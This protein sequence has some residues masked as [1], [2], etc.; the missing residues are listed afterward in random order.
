MRSLSFILGFCAL[1]PSGGAQTATA[2][3]EFAAGM[4][5]EAKGDAIGALE[6]LKRAVALD[7]KMTKGYFAIGSI[8]EAWCG[9]DGGDPLCDV[10][11][12]G[13]QKVTAL[14]PS[15]EDAWKRLGLASYAMNRVDQAENSYRRALSLDESDPNVL[16][17][18]AVLDMHAAYSRVYSARIEHKVATERELID[19]PFCGQVRGKN[20]ATVNEGI[21]FAGKARELKNKN[22]DLMGV[23]GVLRATRAQIQCGDLKS[24]NDDMD[25]SRRWNHLRAKTHSTRDQFLR[26]MPPGPP[27]PPPGRHWW[28]PARPAMKFL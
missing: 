11:I 1:V 27:P 12:S 16:G 6:D 19:S 4:A 3:G 9:T 10:A 8:A 2:E 14:D 5:A 17:A 23:L 25:A 15:R 21:E 24:F 20:L 26:Y 13:Y 18:L 22:V 28:Q 7:P